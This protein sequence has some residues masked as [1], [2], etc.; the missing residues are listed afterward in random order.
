MFR[1]VALLAAAFAGGALGSGVSHATDQSASP[2]HVLDQL[3][4]VLVFVES[5]H[6]DP[7]EREALLKGAVQGMVAELDPH[8]A[9][10]TPK[11][12]QHFN[13]D[14]E[15]VFGGI[16]VE[17]D[18]RDEKVT[19]IA[20][21]P[22]SPAAEAGIRAGDRIIAVDGRLLRGVPIDKIVRWMRGPPKTRIRLKVHR[23]GI[24]EPL[25]FELERRHIHVRSVEGKRLNGGVGYLRVKQFQNGTYEELLEEV[26]SLRTGDEPLGGVIVDLRNNPGGLIDQAEAVANELLSGGAIYSTRHRGRIVEEVRA[27]SGG[28]LTRLPVVVLVNEYSASS[29]ELVAGALQDHGR[30]T[31]IGAPTFGKGSVQTIFQLPSGA[32]LRL[33]TMRYYTP[34]GRAIQAAGIQ[35]DLRIRYDDD[36][37]DGGEAFSEQ[38]LAG[39]LPA[40]HGVE[41]SPDTP[42]LQGGKRPEYTPI[43]RLPQDPAQ[44]KDFA[45]QTAHRMLREAIGGE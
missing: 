41:G 10:M 11:E 19:V 42:V 25:D 21:I 17:V 18:F 1:A 31:V 38:S 2:Y 20:P 15:G 44:G 5:Y 14:T 16:G 35:P 36:D 39:H 45:I 28:A 6:V 8:S 24:D 30:A 23:K 22:G 43:A 12:F 13:E 27:H 4:R 3:A 40:E 9:Y 29:A 26:A 32:G 34:K 37:E 7:V 33:T